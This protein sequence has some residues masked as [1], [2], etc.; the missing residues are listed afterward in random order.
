YVGPREMERLVE[1]FYPRTVRGRLH[2]SVASALGIDKNMVLASA[3]EVEQI[4]RLRRSSLF[5]GLSDGAR[6]DTI[7]HENAGLLSNE[8]FVQGT[9]VD[10]E[11]WQDLLDS[12]REDLQ[13]P[14]ARFRF[15]YLIDDFVATGTSFLRWDDEK[16]RWKGK[17]V[18]FRA[19]ILKQLDTV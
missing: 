4:A 14:N 17:L 9:Q 18:K 1:A 6:I 12:L 10:D 16:K 8:Q 3:P 7:R 15:V 11:K 19:S 2:R 13:D 5:M